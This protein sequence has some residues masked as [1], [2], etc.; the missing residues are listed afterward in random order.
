MIK[1]MKI[2]HKLT[3]SVLVPLITIL[4][5]ATLVIKENIASKN[6]YEDIQKIVK[7]NVKIS[8]LIHETQ[9]ERGATAG[10][11]GTKGKKFGSKLNKQRVLSNQ[12]IQD[13]KQYIKNSNITELLIKDTDTYFSN[14]LKELDKLSATR[15]S[16]SNMSMSVSNALGYYTNMHALFLNFIAKTSQL[17]NDSELTYG[18]LSYYNFLQSKERAG[19][20]RAVGSATFANDRFAKGAKSKL[21][22]LVSEQDA[23]MASFMTLASK[24]AQKFKLKTL[25]GHSVDEVNRMRQVLSNANEVGGFDIDPTYWFDTITKKLGLYRK[26]E[27]FI[28]SNLDVSFENMKKEMD[29]T[30]AVTNLVHETQKERGATATFLGSKGK[31]FIKKLPK[32]RALTNKKINELHTLLKKLSFEPLNKKALKSIKDGIKQLNNINNIRNKV[33]TLSISA[34]KAISYYTSM[35]HIFLEIIANTADDATT[36]KEARDL[37]SWHYFAQAKERGGIERAV[38]ANTFARNQFLVGMKNKFTKLVREQNSYLK[39]FEISASSRNKLYY[40][41]TVSG[42]YIDEVNRMRQIA[43]DAN[44]IGGFGIDSA[45]WFD[46]I[47]QKINLLKKIDDYLSTNLIQSSA[48]KLNDKKMALYGY[49]IFLVINIL[50][51]TLIAYTISKNLNNSIIKIS[52][53]I[54][55]FLLFLNKEHNV[56][57]KIDLISKDELGIVA[58]HVNR[59]IDKI[60]DDIENDMLCVGEAILTLNKTQQGYYNCRV[61]T[62]ASNSQIQTLANTINKMLDVQSSIMTDIL[63]NLEKYSNY[64]FREKIKLD[65]SIGGETKKIVDDV[66]NLVDSITAMLVEN[67]TSGNLLDKTS[68]TLLNNVHVLNTNSNNISNALGETK[69]AIDTIS[70]NINTNMKHVNE[71]SSYATSVTT[72]VEDGQILASKTTESMDNISNEV[73]TIS[74]SISVIDQISFQTNI[75]SLNAAV[76]AATAGEAGKGFA[77][78]A[79]EVRNLASRSADAANEIK[80]IV[81]KAKQ[82]ADEGKVIADDMIEGYTNLNSNIIKTLELIKKFEESSTQQQTSIKQIGLAMDSI[83]EQTKQNANVVEEAKMVA[84]KT[85]NLAKTIVESADEKEFIGKTI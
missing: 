80:N 81:E 45:Y 31:S 83:D 63:S 62:T 22:S 19:I 5:M 15:N 74:E 3:I 37:I 82:R 43:F 33:D 23:Y 9:K 6:M 13:L 60:N 16:V 68:V 59:N 69:N 66:N 67:K 44:T 14:A 42:K 49:I 26:T 11:L 32:Q 78:V 57:E 70:Q 2:K 64:D 36:P 39:S 50:I 1:N 4:I 51:A 41:Q 85:D 76:E 75:L 46:T 25:Q 73:D 56:I 21:E 38:L 40:K 53:G 48:L 30:V 20:E 10:F 54:E 17:S 24:D 35:N 34:T 77:V 84:E 55:Q 29:I 71:M 28:I 58:S 61:N 47:T 79:Q 72:A 7:L 8:K 12:R 52:S 27:Q 18:I 65:A